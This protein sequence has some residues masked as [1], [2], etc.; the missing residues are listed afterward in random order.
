[1]VRSPTGIDP[2]HESSMGTISAS[3]TVTNQK[4]SLT[5]VPTSADA[6]VN[7]R[8]VYIEINGQWYLATATEPTIADN[9][10]TAYTYDALD[11]TTVL[12]KQGR[13]DRDPPSTSTK[14]I[15]AHKGII[16][17]SDGRFLDWSAFQEF[18]SFAPNIV[19]GRRSGAFE[20]DDGTSITC[21]R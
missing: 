10:T 13:T 16:F 19:T 11:S 18:E 20:P 17:G 9:V 3:V 8:N 21:L 6:Q 14:I 7:G 4:I 15:E 2:G 12:N 1:F 5:S